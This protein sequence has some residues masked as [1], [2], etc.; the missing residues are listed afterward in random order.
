MTTRDKAIQIF[1]SA[2][3]SVQPAQLIP[4]HLFISDNKL[5]IFNQQFPIAGLQ[6]IYVIGAGKASAAMAKSVEEILGNL[7]TSGIIVTKYEHAIPLQKIICAEAAHPVPDESGVA[8]TTQTIE[9]ISKAGKG[10]L[11]I[12]LLSGGASSLWVDVPAGLTLKDL[13]TTYELLLKSGATIDEMNTVRKHVSAVKGGQLLQYAPLA[14]WFSFIIS[15]VPGDDLSVIA[16]GPTVADQSTFYD[17]ERIL[18]QY[19]SMTELPPAVSDYIHEGLNGKIRETTKLTDKVFNHV[20]NHIIGSNSIALKT[21]AACAET[22]G[23]NVVMV[24]NTLHGDAAERGTALVRQCKNYTGNLPACWLLGGETTVAVTGKG[25]GGRNQQMALSAQ[26]ELSMYTNNDTLTFTFLAAGTDGTDGPTDAAGAIAAQYSIELANE[27]KLDAA[28][29][30]N[31]NDAYH[32]F[33]QTGGLFRTGPT[34]TNVMD[35][36]IVIAEIKTNG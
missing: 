14:S 22:L 3:T 12:C 21:A 27:K 20:H 15:D 16:S 28:A 33:E 6:N 23:Y 32:F 11:I 25:K 19:N 7:I 29:F 35:L 26:L 36:V 24:E 17:T 2:V 10:D 13:Q 34:Q 4:A 9:L 5:H 8:A 1:N 31:N 18:K 30:L